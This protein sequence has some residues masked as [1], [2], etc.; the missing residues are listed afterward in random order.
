[1]NSPRFHFRRLAAF[2]LT[3]ASAA[4]LSATLYTFQPSDS[5]LADLDHHT[6][7]MWGISSTSMRNELLAGKVILSARL[8]IYDIWD[9]R[10]ETDI[11]HINL[12]DDVKKPSSGNV[13]TISGENPYDNVNNGNYF[14]NL[15][16]SRYKGT[17]A[18]TTWSDPLGG[19]NTGFDFVYQFTAADIA[20]LGSYIVD[21]TASYNGVTGN[22]F[23]LGFDP[24]CHYYNAGVKFKIET[25]DAPR[26]P[27][28]GATLGFLGFALAALGLV[29]RKLRA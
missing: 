24:E 5:D 11:L 3:L 27:D 19:V 21:T 23:G 7:Y 15:V 10:Q 9:W 2:G 1:V 14:A 25:G 4:G 18:L 20:V 12:L 8:T 26:V 28:S 6:A 22:M 16:T 17:S 13:T 29:R